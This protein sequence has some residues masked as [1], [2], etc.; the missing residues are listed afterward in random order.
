MM[1]RRQ[2]DTL[3]FIRNYITDYGKAPLVKEIAEG[4]GITS[5]GTTHRYILALVDAVG[6]LNRKGGCERGLS[7]V[8]Q[9]F[10]CSPVTLPVERAMIQCVVVSQLCTY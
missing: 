7:L 6:S 10:N 2:Q 4:S 9:S 5:R 1:M 3:E 8:E